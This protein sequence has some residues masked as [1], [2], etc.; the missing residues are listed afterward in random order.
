MQISTSLQNAFTPTPTAE[1]SKSTQS[2]TVQP[3]TST[4]TTDTINKDAYNYFSLGQDISQYTNIDPV[5]EQTNKDVVNYLTKIMDETTAD[6][7]K[8]LG[9]FGTERYNAITEFKDAA[10]RIY[11]EIEAE[12][13]SPSL[14]SQRNTMFDM[15]NYPPDHVYTNADLD[16]AIKNYTPPPMNITHVADGLN[17]IT[18]DE[19]NKRDIER[20]KNLYSFSDE[21][22]KTDKFQE[23]YAK[24]K[25]QADKQ[26]ETLVPLAGNFQEVV[27]T[28][29]VKGYITSEVVKQGFSKSEFINYYSNISKDLKNIFSTTAETLSSTSTQ[30]IKDS[31]KLY[32]KITADLK[33]MW[34]YGDLNVR[35]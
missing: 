35:A 31:I 20:F 23:L 13:K 30:A 26:K 1:V 18:V 7:K 8:N 11:A 17:F 10:K 34:G 21:F 16:I 25:V 32:D 22:S 24:Y 3:D 19:A 4:Q 27:H 28:T 15:F 12:K 2:S 14:N 29:D 33:D 6:G 9:A 5:Q